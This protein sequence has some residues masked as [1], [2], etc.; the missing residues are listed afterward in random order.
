MKKKTIAVVLGC[1]ILAIGCLFLILSKTGKIGKAQPTS[2]LFAIKDTNN[3]TKS[4]SP[5]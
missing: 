4:S 2:E 5:T 1:L 3:I